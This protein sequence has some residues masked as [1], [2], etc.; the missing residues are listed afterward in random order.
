MKYSVAWLVGGKDTSIGWVNNASNNIGIIGAYIPKI[1]NA[2]NVSVS[3]TGNP[4]P[5]RIK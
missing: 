2:Q 5:H 1:T 4:P 3:I